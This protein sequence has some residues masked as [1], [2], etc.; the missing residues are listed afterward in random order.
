MEYISEILPPISK[1]ISDLSQV[2]HATNL[3][4]CTPH[5]ANCIHSWY[6]LPTWNEMTSIK[7]TDMIKHKSEDMLLANVLPLKEV[8][9]RFTIF[10]LLSLAKISCPILKLNGKCELNL[11]SYQLFPNPLFYELL[12]RNSESF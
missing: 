2:D 3:F 11:M 7:P 1:H 9:A 4:H 12:A 5:L 8:V 10:I 6:Y